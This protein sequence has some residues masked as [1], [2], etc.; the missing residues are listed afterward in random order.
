MS[1]SSLTLKPEMAQAAETAASNS[2]K[3]HAS[4]EGDIPF[5]V[6]ITH[7]EKI[8]LQQIN[9]CHVSIRTP[10]PDISMILGTLIPI[11][12]EF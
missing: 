11:S 1:R 3:L 9:W 6:V 5:P 8:T 4:G 7:R 12:I 10:D 2:L